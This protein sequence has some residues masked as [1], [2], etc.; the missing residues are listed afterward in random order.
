MYM[1]TCT[2]IRFE[3]LI[4]LDTASYIMYLYMC[5][6]MYRLQA[7]MYMYSCA[8]L[9]LVLRMLCIKMCTIKQVACTCNFI[10][11]T[12]L[13][14]QLHVHVSGVGACTHTHTHT[15][16]H[17]HAHLHTERQCSVYY[18]CMPYILIFD[19][20]NC[21]MCQWIIFVCVE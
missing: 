7:H 5:V 15:H 20:L 21:S 8:Y 6:H 13:Y 18:T 14:T 1:C 17:I 2:C 11:C 10:I 4:M 9:L 12:C 19:L 3:N 16:T